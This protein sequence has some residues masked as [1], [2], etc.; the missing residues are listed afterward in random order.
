M[1][2]DHTV[3]ILSLIGGLAGLATLAWRL[4]DVWIAFL[5]IGVIVE[6]MQGPRVKIRTV[7]E[8][9]NTIARKI[10]AAFLII[11]PEDE[12]VDAT[13]VSLLA[14]SSQSKEFGT[15]T[16]MV[17][18]LASIIA[19]NSE[20]IIGTGRMVIPLPYYYNEN[21]DV[22]DE[23]LSYEQT[24]LI[25]DF[26]IGTYSVRFYIEARPRLHRVVH[27]VFEVGLTTILPPQEL[28]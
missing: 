26:P 6:P 13:V 27:A 25:G 16:D 9:T 21:V 5:H 3:K 17:Q 28:A 7:V 18:T 15:L 1:D 14:K 20:K 19:K 24:I 23:N 12:D 8:N 4:W 2:F 11:G 10:D 22:A